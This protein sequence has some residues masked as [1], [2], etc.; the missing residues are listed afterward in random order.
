MIIE[1][2]LA[3]VGGLNLGLERSWNMVEELIKKYPS[4]TWRKVVDQKKQTCKYL[5]EIKDNN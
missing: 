1:V 5:V 3:L 2:S 4:A